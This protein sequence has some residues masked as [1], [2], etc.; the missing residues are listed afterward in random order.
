MLLAIRYVSDD[1]LM[2]MLVAATA[3][4]VSA[5]ASSS[6]GG[7]MTLQ[8]ELVVGGDTSLTHVFIDYFGY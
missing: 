4:S 5:L 1:C 3:H 8:S 6:R 7:L 2:L